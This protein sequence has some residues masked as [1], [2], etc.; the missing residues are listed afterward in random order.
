MHKKGESSWVRWIK[1]RV[2]NNLNFL[3]ILTGETGVGKS[4]NAL[5]IAYEIDPEFNVYKQCAFSFTEF[6]RAVNGF[7]GDDEELKN[8]KYKVVVFDEV[9]TSVNKREWQS[10]VNKLFNYLISTF[11]HQNIIVLFTSPYSDFVDINTMKLMHAKFECKGWNNKNKSSIRAKILQ[12]N[13]RLSKFYE[14]SLY[15]IH[16][17]KAVKFSGLWWLDKPPKHIYE[18]Y[19]ARK[20]EFTHRL[21]RK[22]TRELE[23]MDKGLYEENEPKGELNPDSMQ[24][25]IWDEA[26]RGYTKQEELKERVS[27]RLNRNVDIAQLNRNIMSMRKKGFDIREYKLNLRGEDSS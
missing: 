21:N 4:Y 7:N 24:P 13:D 17:K 19:E 14:H 15:V 6:M 22:I 5:R 18:P 26:Q 16:N 11:R 12:Y 27:K 3:S 20:T 10:K 9:Q 25:I 8:K 1:K 23:E 2:H